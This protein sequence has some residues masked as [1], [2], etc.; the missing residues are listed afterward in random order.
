[1]STYRQ[2]RHELQLKKEH[3]FKINYMALVDELRLFFEFL[4]RDP[5]LNGILEELR[6]NLPVYDEWYS[7]MV[8]KR[9]ICWPA[10][11]DQRVRLCLVFLEHCINLGDA[12]KPI[13]IAM[14]TGYDGHTFSGAAQYFLEHFFIPLYEYIDQ[15]IEKHKS[16]LYI[17]EKFKLR[18]QWFEK[19]RLY[20]LY[21]KE[22]SKG[23]ATLDKIF[24]QFLFD[25]G[26][27]YPFSTPASASGRADI[28][29]GL[30]TPEPVVVEVKIFDGSSRGRD[31]IR[32]GFRQ[33]HDYMT[34]Y[35]KNIGY[36]IIF[37][38]CDKKLEFILKNPDIPSRVYL[39]NKTI[40]L[41]GIDIYHDFH[42]ASEKPKLKLYK[43][44]QDELVASE[45]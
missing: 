9:R 21:C 12:N 32:Q 1:M 7:K 14:N 11:E 35:N 5:V 30:H 3:L 6:N 44:K 19:E 45:I 43:I 26:I 8:S 18:S 33:V 17:I 31:H 27:E 22:I 36:L 41:I 38:V 40:F 2:V 28:V 16:V 42:P 25:N 23:E 15:H 39:S 37:N 24:R 34:D 29:A 10:E 13:D 4:Q 20:N